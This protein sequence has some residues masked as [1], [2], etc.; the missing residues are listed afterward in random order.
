[1]ADKAWKLL[2]AEAILMKSGVLPTLPL[3]LNYM[4]YPIDCVI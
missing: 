1:M 2:P 3:N 4:D